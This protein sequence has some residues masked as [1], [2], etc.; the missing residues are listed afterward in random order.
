[1]K[2]IVF[3][4]LLGLV[5]AGPAA[6]KGPSKVTITGPGLAEPI[7]LSGDPESNVGSRFG[8]LVDHSGWFA[9][10][11]QQSPDPTSSTRPTGRLGPRYTA[12]YVVPIGGDASKPVRQQLYPFAAGGPVTH[13]RAGQPVFVGTVTH[14]GWYRAPIA[15][16][17]TLVAI[18]LPSKPPVAAAGLSSGAW[19][20]IATA[21][22]IA[23]AAAAFL[24]RRH[25]RPRQAP[26]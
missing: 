14:G 6:A 22:A 1:M 17:R 25:R 18:G 8:R 13:T 20:G 26:A 7:V 11:F 23:L 16:R 15:L 21:C 4:L 19:A 12:T 2:R 9:E 3:V 24:A 10:V 5:L